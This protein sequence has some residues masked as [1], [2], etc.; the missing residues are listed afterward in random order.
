MSLPCKKLKD[1]RITIVYYQNRAVLLFF[2]RKIN[3]AQGI[4]D[5]LDKIFKKLY[6][7]RRPWMFSKAFLFAYKANILECQEIEQHYKLIKYNTLENISRVFNFT[8]SYHDKI[9]SSINIKLALFWLVYFRQDLPETFLSD[10][11]YNELISD[12]ENLGLSDLKTKI[13]NIVD[14]FEYK[15]LLDVI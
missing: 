2:E 11:F 4:I 5:L 15:K 14:N 3:E 8:K 1:D 13:K 10:D 6:I 7:N 9:D 12:L